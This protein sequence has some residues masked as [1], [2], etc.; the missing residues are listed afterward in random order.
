MNLRL[1]NPFI[2]WSNWID[3]WNNC[4]AMRRIYSY[5]NYKYNALYIYVDRFKKKRFDLLILLW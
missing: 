2:W 5:N 3:R 1:N 4:I